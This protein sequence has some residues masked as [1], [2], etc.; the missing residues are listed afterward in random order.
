MLEGIAP[1]LFTPFDEDGEI[2]AEGLRRIARFE[3]DGGVHA[4]GINGFASEAYK[5]TDD[6]R[7]QTVEIVASELAGALPLIIGIA[8]NSL[9]AA[10]Q[11]ARQFAQ[12]QPAALMTLP[13]PTMDNGAKALVEFYVAF[14]NAVESPIILQQ[15]PHIAQYRHTELPAEALAEIAGRAPAVATFKLEGPGSAAKM[16]ELAPLLGG[17]ASMLGGGGGITV[18]EE[19]RNGAAGLIPGVGFNEIFLAA[20]DSWKKGETAAAEAMI[21]RGAPLTK[22]VSGKGHE[23]SLHVRKHLMKR[24]GAIDSAYVRKPTVAFDECDLP[25]FFAIVDALDLRVS[26]KN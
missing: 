23:Y 19:L 16:K 9:E 13:P 21:Q 12:V 24:H 5:M 2:D 8:P 3:V 6:E 14:G 1:I 18:L 10:V 4:I 7:R 22:A 25:G 20:W 26:A 17:E 11:Q 15:A